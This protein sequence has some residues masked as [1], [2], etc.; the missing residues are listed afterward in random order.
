MLRLK[1][2][3]LIALLIASLMFVLSGCCSS[4]SE[5]TKQKNSIQYCPCGCTHSKD[6]SLKCSCVTV[7]RI[8][9]DDSNAW[10]KICKYKSTCQCDGVTENCGCVIVDSPC[11]CEEDSCD[12]S[13]DT[14]DDNNCGCTVTLSQNNNNDEFMYCECG[15]GFKV[16]D[17]QCCF[18]KEKLKY[19]VL[20]QNQNQK[21]SSGV[22][23]NPTNQANPVNHAM[24][25][26]VRTTFG[27]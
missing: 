11:T 18:C 20:S 13:S 27:F 17:C 14:S 16:F 15:C 7:N 2:F 25:T 9:T 6:H 3:C 22:H 24:R 1:S 19:I 4:H 10:N 21:S 23:V 5:N 26:S 8:E 12:C